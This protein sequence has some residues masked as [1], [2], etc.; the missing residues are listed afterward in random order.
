MDEQPKNPNQENVNVPIDIVNNNV[1]TPIIADTT[2]TIA[3]SP[4]PA[5][6]IADVITATEPI[7]VAEPHL[8]PVAMHTNP[9]D[10]V[11][12]WLTYA[13]WGWTAIAILILSSMVMSF[14]IIDADISSSLPYSIAA[15]SVLLPIS[16]ICEFL[17]KKREPVKKTG[18]SS[19]IMIIHAVLFALCAAGSLVIIVLNLVKM[20]IETGSSEGTSVQVAIYTAIIMFAVYAILL[21][22]TIIPA[23]LFKLRIFIM[24]IMTL[25][26]IVLTAF[27]IFGPIANEM[28]TKN[29]KL[30]EDNISTLVSEIEDYVQVKDQLPN[31]LTDLE[32]SGD[33]KKLVSEKLVSYV[34]EGKV[35]SMSSYPTYRYQLCANYVESSNSGYSSYSNNSDD[36][37]SYIYTYNHDAGKVCYKLEAFASMND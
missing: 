17:Y 9:I 6:P 32:L 34:E 7:A 30:I 11:I 36:Y 10:I 28:Q 29:D 23:K 4:S 25:I 31:S 33:A 18:A 5:E 15:V 13:F 19:V 12:Q 37:E 1:E 24:L 3:A 26:C 14:Y 35:S 27:S 20:L 2:Q 16:I 8:Q 21:F 22:R